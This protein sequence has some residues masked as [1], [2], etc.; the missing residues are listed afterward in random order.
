MLF[1]TAL[2]I[3]FFSS[4]LFRGLLKIPIDESKINLSPYLPPIERVFRYVALGHCMW[5]IKPQKAFEALKIL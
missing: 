1:E 4:L 2:W 3:Y 5:E